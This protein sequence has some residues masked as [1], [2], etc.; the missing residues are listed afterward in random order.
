MRASYGS[1]GLTRQSLSL[2]HGGSLFEEGFTPFPLRRIRG[3]FELNLEAMETK[4]I[5]LAE[6]DEN[7]VFF[8]RRA[9]EKTSLNLSIQ[10][11]TDGQSAIDYLNGNGE[12]RDRKTFPIPQA[13]LLDL[14]LP[15]LHGFEVLAWIRQQPLLRELPVMILTSSPED[16]DRQE[17]EKLGAQAYCVKP[18]TREM[19]LGVLAPL[20]GDLV[21][22]PSS[23]R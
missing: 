17:A 9:I 1:R 7:D 5:L 20:L 18:P 13:V 10:V 21:A 23:I 19:V 11:A 2:C 6:D 4:T 8:M 14:K 12:Y 22:G 3:L 16:R 15:Y